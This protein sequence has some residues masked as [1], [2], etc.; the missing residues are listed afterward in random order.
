VGVATGVSGA[1]HWHSG[2]H[3]AGQL[4]V[5]LGGTHPGPAWTGPLIVQ[6][7]VPGSQHAEPQHVCASVHGVLVVHAGTPQVP[8]SQNMPSPSQTVPHSPQLNRSDRGSTHAPSQQMYSGFGTG[9]G[10]HPPPVSVPSSAAVVAAP[11]PSALPPPVAEAD[12]LAPS[13][14][15]A[16]A[17]VVADDPADDPASSPPSVVLRSAHP[18]VPATA[19]AIATIV[20]H[21]IPC[22]SSRS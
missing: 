19:R 20:I 13:P 7:I 3:P 9:R 12:A 8:W 4:P 16:D 18:C 1:V 21:R 17:C 2:A 11:V 14:P 10:T 22:I 15:D 6:Q 5:S